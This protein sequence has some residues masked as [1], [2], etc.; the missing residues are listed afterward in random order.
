MTDMNEQ[1]FYKK[2]EKVVGHLSFPHSTTVNRDGIVTK[3][4]FEAS[5]KEGTTEPFETDDKHPDGSPVLGY[6]DNYEKKTL[7]KKQI[8][9]L[10]ELIKSL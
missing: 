10:G 7:T 2:L 8:E 5:W 9:D 6:K 4:E 3:F 1:D